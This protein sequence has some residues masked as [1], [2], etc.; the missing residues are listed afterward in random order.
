MKSGGPSLERHIV[1]VCLGW[2]DYS[3]ELFNTVLNDATALYSTIYHDTN[4]KYRF[5]TDP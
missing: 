4:T 2:L 5:G 1:T 3:T